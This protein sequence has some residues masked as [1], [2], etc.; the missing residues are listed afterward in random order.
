MQQKLQGCNKI[1]TIGAGFI[2]VELSDELRKAGKDV[3]LIEKLPNILGLAF[4][5]DI[6]VR[7]QELLVNRGIILKPVWRAKS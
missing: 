4:D 6:S 2:G 7:A 3:L 5:E 1:I